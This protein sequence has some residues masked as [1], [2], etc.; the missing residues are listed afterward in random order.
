MLVE[1]SVVAVGWGGD[2]LYLNFGDD[3][4]QDFTARIERA[5]V[6]KLARAGMALEELTGRRL[7]LRGWLFHLGGPM[8]ELSGPAQIEVLP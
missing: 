3:R 4:R 1:G 8:I 5:D 6:R 7:R 2:R